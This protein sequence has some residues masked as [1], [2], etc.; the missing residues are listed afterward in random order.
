MSSIA[1]GEAGCSQ[2]R[3]MPVFVGLYWNLI[4]VPPAVHG[5][6]TFCLARRQPVRFMF[7]LSGF[8]RSMLSS[9][10]NVK[11]FWACLAG[12]IL[13]WLGPLLATT[14]AKHGGGVINWLAEAVEAVELSGV[15]GSLQYLA[16]SYQWT[17]G[18][19]AR[20]SH[21]CPTPISLH[22]RQGA[23]V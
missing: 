13:R 10:G 4:Y 15:P 17:T 7:S 23:L 16:R 6:M 2:R 14:P 12:S 11:R 8:L 19:R 22:L 21:R 9:G 1:F 5:G 20:S 18:C 3:D